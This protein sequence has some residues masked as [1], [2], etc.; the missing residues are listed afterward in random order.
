MYPPL[1]DLQ[2]YTELK[3][4][5]CVE[6]KE[7][8]TTIK[9]LVGALNIYVIEYEIWAKAVQEVIGRVPETGVHLELAKELIAKHKTTPS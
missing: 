9:E 8:D 7:K 1:E 5:E 4:G 3:P 6:C 2:Y